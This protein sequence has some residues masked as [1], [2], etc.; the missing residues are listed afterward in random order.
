MNEY[1]SLPRVCL[2]L[3]TLLVLALPLFAQSVPEPEAPAG[4]SEAP[5]PG[6]AIEPSSELPEPDPESVPPA[7]PDE[8]PIETTPLPSPEDPPEVT[9][10]SPPDPAPTPSPARGERRDSFPNLNIYL[11]EGEFDIRLRRLIKNVLFEGQVS[12]NFVDGDVSTFLRYKYYARN[13]TYKI[14]LFDSL[15]FESIDDTS[16]D[17]DR[18]RGALVQFERPV[19]YNNRYLLLL[20]NDRLQFGDVNDPDNNKSN[21][22]AKIAYQFGSPFDE[23][24]NA[25]AGE[26]R[27][28][29]TPVLTAYRELGPQN[30]A[31]AI[32][33][34]QSFEAGGDYRY[35]KVEAEGLKRW[36]VGSTTFLV[37]RVHV[38]SVISRQDS[39]LVPDIP[40]DP[41]Q[42][43]LFRRASGLFLIPRYDLIRIGDRGAMKA[44]EGDARGTDSAHMTSELFTPIF[45]NRDH[46]TGIFTWT[47]LYGILYAGVGT[48]GYRD[49]V[50]EALVGYEFGDLLVDAGL[51]FEV[52]LFVRDYEVFI[53]C[54][55]ARTVSTPQSLEGDDIRFSVRTAR[56]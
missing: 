9:S 23:R 24:L 6:P 32:A 18:V 44:I 40:E 10:V 54:V 25:L 34:T 3:A 33:L 47:N 49:R 28:R 39:G 26:S 45:R 5:A 13:L 15:E 8:D 46:R 21:S 55:Y 43:E 19:D 51:G 2:I 22:Y 12:Y 16:G 42:Q 31:L 30:T 27:G 29:T 17:F 20:Q 11:P 35:T 38:G 53:N 37:S 14:G 50:A 41:D 36:E 1:N 56:F 4:S 7:T 48:V 52:S